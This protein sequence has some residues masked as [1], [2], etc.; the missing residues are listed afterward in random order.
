MAIMAHYAATSA[1]RT[2]TPRCCSRRRRCVEPNLPPLR[3]QSRDTVI[4]SEKLGFRRSSTQRYSVWQIN[5][6]GDNDV[7]SMPAGFR[8][9]LVGK[10]LI[11]KCF[12]SDI[13]E[14]RFVGKLQIQTFS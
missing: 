8:R 13:A 10:T 6:Y 7:I 5:T 3:N 12:P 11:Y 14:I 1:R 2:N 4:I 9:H